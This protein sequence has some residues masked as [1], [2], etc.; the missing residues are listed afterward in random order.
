MVLVITEFELGICLISF[1]FHF[2]ITVVG[3]LFHASRFTLH[4]SRSACSASFL[5]FSFVF[6]ILSFAA[7]DIPLF[8]VFLICF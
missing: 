2:L 6:C 7:L 8:L 4:A 5:A 1:G 3:I